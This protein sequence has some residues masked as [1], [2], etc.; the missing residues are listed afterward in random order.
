M[1]QA[2]VHNTEHRRS[3]PKARSCLLFLLLLLGL[4]CRAEAAALDV[5]GS[6]TRL[7]LGPHAE[8]L[9]DPEGQLTI[10]QIL[11]DTR[12]DWRSSEQTTLNFSFSDSSYWLRFSFSNPRETARLR[13]LELAMP[14]HDYV[15]VHVVSDDTVVRS[16]HSGD[17]LPFHARPLNYRNVVVP[18]DFPA[19]TRYEVYLR[20]ATHDGLYDATPLYLWTQQG[21]FDHTQAEQ[22]WYGI[23]YGA[24]LALLAYN[25]LLFLSTRERQFL[26]YVAYLATFFVWNFTFRGYAYQYWWPNWPTL[27][28]QMVAASGALIYITLTAFTINF[29]DLRHQAPRLTRILLGLT[30]AIGATLPLAL[31]GYYA[32]TFSLL[33]PAGIAYLLFIYAVAAHLSWRGH[34]PARIYLVAWTVL[35][36]GAVLYYL[37]VL[38][39]LPS[40]FVTE[41]ALQIGSGLEF[42]LLA[43]GLAYKLNHRKTMRL[44]AEQA[45]SSMQAELSRELE[46]KVRER[47]NDLETL[48]R[49]LQEMAA[50]DA[51]TGL[52]NRR[53]F[54]TLFERE[55]SRSRRQGKPFCFCIMDIDRFKE[56]NDSYGHQAGDEV[57][58]RVARLLTDHLRRAGDYAFRLGGEEFGVILDAEGLEQA[59]DRIETVRNAIEAE[60]IDQNTAPGGVLT[61]S[62]GLVCCTDYDAMGRIHDVYLA[63]D[64]ALYLAKAE[65]RN[66][67]RLHEPGQNHPR[68][69]RSLPR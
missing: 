37:R 29:L 41:N 39:A 20:L 51:L 11:S 56:Y 67:L 21:F 3:L 62:F 26:Y 64:N 60:G 2:A 14:L 16:V 9:E 61:A 65:G 5:S 23:Y 34:V 50:T 48:N 13:L 19:G 55:F 36:A 10:E 49:R 54:N 28:N 32:L 4:A 68:A 8:I 69:D 53:H 52:G 18:I 15:D 6:H 45:F 27:N 46:D 7:T 35:I 12:F 58:R 31:L 25:L 38:G 17:R 43:F 57:L 40:S 30:V 59:V 1:D 47:T 22:L 66:Q 24:L 63:A 42:V 33:I 44:E